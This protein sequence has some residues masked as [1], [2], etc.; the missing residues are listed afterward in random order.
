M[1]LLQNHNHDLQQYLPNNQDTLIVFV[2]DIGQNRNEAVQAMLLAIHTI[3]RP[4]DKNEKIA[5]EDN[6]SLGKLQEEG[7]LSEEPIILGCVINT[8]LLTIALPKKKAKYWLADLK[9]NMKTRRIS[10]KQ[11][12]TLVGRFGHSAAAWPLSRYFL[13]RLRN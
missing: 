1:E 4:L 8:H 9:H 2:S 6:L 7:T 12:E 13:N 10:H 11:V 3:Y 5:R